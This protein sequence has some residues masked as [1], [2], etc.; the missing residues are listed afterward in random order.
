MRLLSQVEIPTSKVTQKTMYPVV[1]GQ[2]GASY[3][4]AF[5]EGLQHLGLGRVKDRKFKFMAENENRS[6]GL[7]NT[8]KRKIIMATSGDQ[9]TRR[10]SKIGIP[11]SKHNCYTDAQ[12]QNVKEKQKYDWMDEWIRRGEG[13]L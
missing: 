3:A 7:A 2:K 1:A 8:E 6:K 5:M 10:T 12:L 11:P 4:N 13:N 9:W